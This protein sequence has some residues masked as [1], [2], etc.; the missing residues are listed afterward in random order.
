MDCVTKPQD[1]TLHQ[2]VVALL[3]VKELI[4]LDPEDA[5]PVFFFFITLE[6]RVER[7]TSP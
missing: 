6:P 1:P 2:A 3:F 5:M 4:L 7:N